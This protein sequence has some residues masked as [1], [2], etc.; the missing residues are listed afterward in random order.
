MRTYATPGFVNA[1]ME[2]RVEAWV[3]EHASP[4]PTVEQLCIINEQVRRWN[5]SVAAYEDDVYSMSV[6]TA[7]PALGRCRTSRERSGTRDGVSTA[8]M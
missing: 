2:Q 8:P 6:S 7:V 3:L 1:L 4:R 5:A